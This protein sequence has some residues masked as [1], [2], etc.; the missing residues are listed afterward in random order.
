MPLKV[1]VYYKNHS[2][3]SNCFKT[4]K[5]P[6]FLCYFI[7]VYRYLNEITEDSL[8]VCRMVKKTNKK[9]T[10]THRKQL[11]NYSGI[12]VIAHISLR[13]SCSSSSVNFQSW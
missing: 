7:W 12:H 2:Q 4:R 6:R 10:H 5:L 3:S 13:D 8:E 9:A 11:T 1:N